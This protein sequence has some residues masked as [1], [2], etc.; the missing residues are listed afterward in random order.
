M[1]RLIL[2]GDSGPNLFRADLADLVVYFCSRFV[3]GPL[4]SAD[5]LASYL[6]ARLPDHRPADH[7]SVY[8]G[9]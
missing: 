2:A 7:W 9:R 6:G 4:P 8:V 5:K 3:W 1:T